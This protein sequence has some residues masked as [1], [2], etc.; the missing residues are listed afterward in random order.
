MESPL[1]EELTM[2]G[3][4]HVV[5]DNSVHEILLVKSKSPIVE[6]KISACQPQ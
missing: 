3:P 2:N 4:G 6:T 1:Q 5:Y